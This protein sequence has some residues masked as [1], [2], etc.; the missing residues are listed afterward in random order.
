MTCVFCASLGAVFTCIIAYCVSFSIYC[1]V[2]NVIV[3]SFIQ[4]PIWLRFSDDLL[5]ILASYHT[6]SAKVNQTLFTVNLIA[7]ASV[8]ESIMN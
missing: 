7:I 8:P 1:S 6:F 2:G 5:H 3:V 4:I